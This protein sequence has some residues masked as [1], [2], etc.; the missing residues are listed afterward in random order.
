[1]GVKILWIKKKYFDVDVDSVTWIEM[2]KNLL[3][4]NHRV[5]LLTGFKRKK[6]SFFGLEDKIIYL[7]SIRLKFLNH[8]TFSISLFFYFIF[9]LFRLKPDIVILDTS[10]VTV[11]F[12]F[13]LLR[14]LLF[15]KKPKFILDIRTF[16][17]ETLQ[18]FM[19]WVSLKISKFTVDGVTF[20]TPVMKRYILKRLK[21][22]EN[23]TGIWS[24]GVNLAL[25]DPD[26]LNAKKLEKLKESLKLG[27]SFV[28][29]YHGTI[30][31]DRGILESI[32]A[33]SRVNARYPKTVFI[34]VGDGPLM[35]E[36]KE[37]VN[38]LKLAKKV[39]IIGR[40]PYEEI[41]YFI[42]LA[43]VGILAF[44]PNPLRETCSPIKLFEYIAMKKP[45]IL[46]EISAHREVIPEALAFY[47]PSPDP[48]S[49]ENGMI[50][51]IEKAENIEQM[52]ERL[53]HL[54]E[55]K[56][57]WEAQADELENF[58]IKTIYES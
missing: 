2:I 24:S 34:I 32:E 21:F 17:T 57:S 33:F 16:Y 20:I 22:P 9:A 56:F 41:K 31:T 36:V 5:L 50:R 37:L 53:R 38:R 35:T 14:K 18:N 11:L 52:G 8:L 28:F 39:L 6:L 19:F 1:M 12:P 51:A 26:R 29:M 58:L 43:Q 42:A 25:F 23:K 54:I 48:K 45:V 30:D 40:V 4:K 55:R 13:M 10:T 15:L 47:I 44:P 3:K 27:D 7:P 46:T 49:I